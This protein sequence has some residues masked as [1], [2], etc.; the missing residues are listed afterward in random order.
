MTKKKGVIGRTETPRERQYALRRRLMAHYWLELPEFMAELSAVMERWREALAQEWARRESEDYPDSPL[1]GPPA[2]QEELQA[3]T[4]KWGLRCPWAFPWLHYCVA[5]HVHVDTLSAVAVDTNSPLC[6]IAL[7]IGG[8]W[9]YGALRRERDKSFPPCPVYDP[10]PSV[11][12]DG[13]RWVTA[14][15]KFRDDVNQ[16]MEQVDKWYRD[17]GYRLRDEEPGLARHVSWLFQRI[18][19]K[20]VPR[21]IS[22]EE[23]V[24]QDGV[25]K[26]IYRL[27]KELSISLPR[28]R[29]RRIRH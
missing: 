29:G 20:K 15:Q 24:G 8:I 6:P 28:N 3:L 13:R 21:D 26:A 17:R 22:T 16:H 9:E 23:G 12:H 25:E 1:L 19:L 7:D 4:E 11:V 10:Y 18:A 27:A 14:K 5:T 2:Y